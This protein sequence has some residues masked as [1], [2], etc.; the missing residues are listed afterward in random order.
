MQIL[1][2]SK[3]ASCTQRKRNNIQWLRLHCAQCLQNN[4]RTRNIVSMHT[5]RESVFS[6]EPSEHTRPCANLS[7][8]DLS[9][10]ATILKDGF[11]DCA[12]LSKDDISDC[13]TLLKDDL[14]VCAT[15]LIAISKMMWAYPLL[16]ILPMASTNVIKTIGY[17][18]MHPDTEMDIVASNMVEECPQI[19]NKLFESSA[20]IQ[21][22]QERI[23]EQIQVK[24]CLLTSISIT[25]HCGLFSH[26]SIINKGLSKNI[27][28]IT[29]ESCANLHK[30]G[31]YNYAGH[32]ITDIKPNS[33]RNVDIVEYGSVDNQG[34]C[35]G[36]DVITPHGTHKN[37]VVIT[38]L[39]IEL[40]DYTSVYNS[41]K[42]EIVLED[43][44]VCKL[45]EER[46]FHPRRGLAI[47]N[48]EILDNCDQTVETIYS[49]V[50][51]PSYLK[52]NPKI[53]QQY[54]REMSL[55]STTNKMYLHCKSKH[56]HIS[57]FNPSSPPKSTES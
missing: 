19:K 10:C 24:H 33:S 30:D 56:M 40:T 37:V 26:M 22:I 7:K 57:V 34:N 11:S 3:T 47:W 2:A 20:N 45:E 4:G 21:L 55:Q 6:T 9:D 42:N 29:K 36:V 52:I 41:Q 48:N 32:I 50:G 25:M 53:I 8:D 15:L 54:N 35:K 14:S 51:Q 38:T 39:D 46:C 23:F 1:P 16:I 44:S 28:Q 13:A 31:N 27:L 5:R 49:K 43:G 18:C 12:N 17:D